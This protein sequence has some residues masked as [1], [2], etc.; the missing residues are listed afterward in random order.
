[1]TEL[2]RVYNLLVDVLIMVCPDFNIISDSEIEDYLSELEGDYYTFFDTISLLPLQEGGI[3]TKN[4]MNNIV[5]LKNLINRIPVALWNK[6][7]FKKDAYWEEA[8]KCSNDILNS[9]GISKRQI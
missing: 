4:Q 1:M 8:R 3:L 6:D 5:E 7:D 2:S 9:L